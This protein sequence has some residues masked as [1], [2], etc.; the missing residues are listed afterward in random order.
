MLSAGYGYF[1]V[2]WSVGQL[3][4]LLP[5]DLVVLSAFVFFPLSALAVVLFFVNLKKIMHGPAGPAAPVSSFP[6]PQA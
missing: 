1:A 4:V 5:N 6:P 3:L 2:G